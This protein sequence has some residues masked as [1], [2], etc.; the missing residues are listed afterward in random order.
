MMTDKSIKIVEIFEDENKTEPKMELKESKVEVKSKVEAADNILQD[1]VIKYVDILK[2]PK[3]Y[4]LS[5]E[6]YMIFGRKYF[7]CPLK[8]INDNIKLLD[9]NLREINFDMRVVDVKPFD[10]EIKT[11]YNENNRNVLTDDMNKAMAEVSPRY[12]HYINYSVQKKI[13]I[14]CESTEEPMHI[15]S[16]EIN[17]LVI[18][19]QN[20]IVLSEKILF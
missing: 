8:L 1:P 16:T 14:T 10:M 19:K 13:Y 6:S 12:E 9:K 5:K 15:S 4:K 20:N 3:N 11:L 2:T 17:V 7:E 18:E